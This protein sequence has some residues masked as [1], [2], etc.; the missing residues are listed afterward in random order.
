MSDSKKARWIKRLTIIIVLFLVLLTILIAGSDASAQTRPPFY[1][2]IQSFKKLD[3]VAPAPSGK[4]LFI[5]SSSFT[6]WKDVADYFPGHTIINRGFGGSILEDL[7]RYQVDIIYPYKPKQIVIYCGENDIASSD[8]IRVETVVNRF[9]QLFSDIRRRL[10]KT[11]ILFVSMKPSPSRWQMQDRMVA[12]NNAIRQFLL[13]EK[14]TDYVD[15]YT[16]MLKPD[17]R[18]FPELFLS[19]SLHMT[20]KGYAVWK[21][22]IGPYL[23][24]K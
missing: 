10:P 14:R 4:I 12:A 3:S 15:V 9:K 18:P 23:I 24:R 21:E 7:L 20:P 2:D 11:R 13:T 1:N 19:D 6:Y 8:T 5:G 22:K 16:P 17:G